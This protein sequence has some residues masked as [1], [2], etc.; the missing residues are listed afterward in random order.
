VLTRGGAENY[1][2]VIT[3]ETAAVQAEQT[4][5]NLRTRPLQASIGLISATGGVWTTADLPLEKLL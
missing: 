5:L 4:A 3:A 1:L 2:Q